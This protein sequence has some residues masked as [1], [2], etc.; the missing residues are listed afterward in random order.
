MA[1]VGERMDHLFREATAAQNTSRRAVTGVGLV[2]SGLL[3][4]AVAATR[5]TALAAVSHGSLAVFTHQALFFHFS[6]PRTW[7][8]GT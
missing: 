4:T 6:A 3:S 5:C 2:L 7:K 8:H 1:E